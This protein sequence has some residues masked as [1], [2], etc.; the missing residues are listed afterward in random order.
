MTIK[1]LAVAFLIGFTFL[2]FKP[3]FAEDW[4]GTPE[5]SEM[6]FGAL[7]GLGIVDGEAAYALIGTASK[8]I[9]HHGF[10]PD[11]NDS[12]SIEGQFGPMFFS[13]AT[14]WSYSAHLRWDFRKDA[15]W[16]LFAMGGVSGNIIS[17]N[18]VTDFE[19]MPRFGVGAFWK[20]TDQVLLR[21]EVAH[22]LI[23]VGVNL[24]F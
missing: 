10:I 5:P 19:I 1:N 14:A 6:S 4:K 2:N 9:V 12:V 11:I 20:M 13:G 21:G 24:P 17:K 8:K 16:T 22:N 18:S 7:T 3:V 23:G 15:M